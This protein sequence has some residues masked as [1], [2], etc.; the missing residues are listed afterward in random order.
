VRVR[1]FNDSL[2]YERNHRRTH[3]KERYGVI[4]KIEIDKDLENIVSHVCGLLTAR[5]SQSEC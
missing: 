2:N 1:V 4:H 3:E 5:V